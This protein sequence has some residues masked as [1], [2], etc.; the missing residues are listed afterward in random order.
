MPSASL[1]QVHA[2]SDAGGLQN[3]T[4]NGFGKTGCMIAPILHITA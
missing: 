3:L 4:A 2:L 1:E